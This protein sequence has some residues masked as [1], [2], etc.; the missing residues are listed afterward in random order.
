MG[1]KR[2]NAGPDDIGGVVLEIEGGVAGRVR[3][4]DLP[5]RCLPAAELVARAWIRPV[6]DVDDHRSLEAI[7]RRI[8]AKGAEGVHLPG[9]AARPA[10]PEQGGESER[11]PGRA[12]HAE[13]PGAVDLMKR[14]PS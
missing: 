12:R 5:V 1:P 3:D 8:V 2:A 7:A 9:V 6:D 4:E 14:S 10:E 11:A 13:E